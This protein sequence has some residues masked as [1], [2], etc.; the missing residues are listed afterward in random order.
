L[1]DT[2]GVADDNAFNVNFVAYL[3][4]ITDALDKLSPADFA[5]DLALLDAVVTSLQVEPDVEQG[6]AETAMPSDET[7]PS[8]QVAPPAS[9]V[10]AALLR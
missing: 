9:L 2:P 1:P 5:P 7:T 8:P 6:G 4:E 10:V 3:T